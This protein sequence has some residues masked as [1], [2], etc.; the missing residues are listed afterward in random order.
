MRKIIS[1]ERLAKKTQRNQLIVGG[2][3]VLM[4]ILGTA[5]YAFM[6]NEGGTKTNT[7]SEF[8][9]YQGIRFFKGSSYWSF[10]YDNQAFVTGNNPNE[11][12]GTVGSTTKT[13]SNYKDKVLYFVTDSGE[14]N[15][16]VG[17]NLAYTVKRIGMA[18]IPGEDCLGNFPVKDCN[19]D[20][21]IIVREPL[22][23]ESEGISQKG[24][25]VF[26]TANY[27]N[28]TKYADSFLFDILGIK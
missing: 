21:I 20:N 1:K 10:T 3:M 5:G 6:S 13:V 23:N 11:T 26:I 16:E 12:I 27:D 14:P 24:N 18:C 4:M 25:C 2:I 9:D 22:K 28:Q 8:I 17:R 7:G 19:I 15:I